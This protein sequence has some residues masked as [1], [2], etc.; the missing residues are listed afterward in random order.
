MTPGL[1]LIYGL[2][3]AASIM[4]VGI[5]FLILAGAW[6]ALIGASKQHYMQGFNDGIENALTQVKNTIDTD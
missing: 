3:T 6:L 5:V 1:W 2:A 4:V